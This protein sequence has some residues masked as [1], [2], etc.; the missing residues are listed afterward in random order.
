[1]N[2]QEVRDII[3][4]IS[5]SHEHWVLN[6][7]QLHDELK[8]KCS[9]KTLERRLKEVGYFRC[10]ACQKPF[11]TQEQARARW[12]WG[13]AHMF[14]WL[15]WRRILWLDEVTFLIGGRKCKEKVTRKKGER[16]HPDCIQ[17]QMHRG[18][19]TPVHAFGAIRYGYKSQLLFIT[20]TG[21]NGA[22]TQKNYL[23][24]VLEKALV[25]ILGAF[26]QITL[27]KGLQPQ[28][29]EDGNSAHGHKSINNVC[30]IWRRNHGITLFP[31]PSTSPDMNPIEKCWR[32]IKQALHRRNRQPTNEAEMQAAV[33]ELW[34]E[35]P[36]EWINGL[37]DK[38]D[39]WVHELIKRCGWSTAN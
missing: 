30:A 22:F 2:E 20:G 5:D 33:T 36:Q 38:Q 10:T 21:K 18:H 9:P 31:H 16:F 26:G 34:E 35:I 32:R 6:Y 23:E 4:Y 15:E 27:P 14:W 37:I 39:Y 28:F 17:F 12:I 1:L 29:M 19:T 11:L 24:Q 3:E 13:L 8:L 25:G 7:Q